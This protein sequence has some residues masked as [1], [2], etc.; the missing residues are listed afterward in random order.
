MSGK[1]PRYYFVAID[2]LPERADEA[3]AHLFELGAQGV[4]ERDATT[5][6]K[7]TAG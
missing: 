4:E 5:L 2:V 1:P 7:G 3:S 6:H